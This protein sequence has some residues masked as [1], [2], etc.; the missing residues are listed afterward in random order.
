VKRISIHSFDNSAVERSES[1]KDGS[2]FAFYR[3]RFIIK[4]HRKGVHRTMKTH[5]YN[6]AIR[7]L[8]YKEGDQFIAHA[9]ELDIPAYGATEEAAKK[10]LENLVENQLSFAGCKEN[11]EMV[12][13]PAPNEFFDRWEK[14]HLAQLRGETVSEKS[15]EFVTEAAVFVYT[16][17]EVRRLRSAGKRDFSKVENLASAAA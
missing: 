5:Y 12:H 8:I 11:H 17:E 13:F 16:A 7:V 1:G 15:L 6:L 14:A 10:E 4:V 9:L 3:E 2:H